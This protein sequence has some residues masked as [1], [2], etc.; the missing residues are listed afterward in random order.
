MNET[1]LSK[2]NIANSTELMAMFWGYDAGDMNVTAARQS[3]AF[4]LGCAVCIMDEVKYLFFEFCWSNAT[5]KLDVAHKLSQ[6]SQHNFQFHVA[7]AWM[8][9]DGLLRTQG[10][11]KKQIAMLWDCFRSK[12]SW[13]LMII[14]SC[15][16][17][18]ISYTFVFLLLFSLYLARCINFSRSYPC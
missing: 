16:W 13:T 1:R 9:P 12:I 5:E 17:L 6:R 10:Q 15:N 7:T 8:K 18:V 2:Q 14:K 4:T 11:S 3:T